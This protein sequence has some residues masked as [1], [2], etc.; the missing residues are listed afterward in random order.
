M[1]RS[2]MP[3]AVRG[4]GDGP[5]DGS[6]FR[7]ARLPRW[8]RAH[9]V[10]LLV[11]GCAPGH[12]WLDGSNP[13]PS[14]HDPADDTDWWDGTQAFPDDE[15]DVFGDTAVEIRIPPPIVLAHGFFGFD[16]FAGADFITYFYGVRE[17]LIASGERHVYTPAVDPFSDSRTR[18]DALL[19]HVLDILAETGAEKVNLVAH[20]Q[21]GLDARR[22]A[23]LRPDLVESVT[24]VATPHTGTPV[25]DVAVGAVA[26]SAGA[27]VDALVAAVAGPLWSAAGDG[28][29]LSASL[30][31]L[32]TAGAVAFN[33]D[34]PPG[35]G[36]V[37]YSIGGRSDRHAGG[38]DCEVSGRMPAFLRQWQ[39]DLDPIDPLLALTEG[40]ADGG[41]GA[42]RPNDGL[43]RVFDSRYGRFLGCIPAD[44]FDEIGHL[45][46]D[47]AGGVNRFDHKAFYRE[48]VAWLRAEGH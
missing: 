40:I 6:P 2:T 14:D 34:H 5:E 20:S 46:D 28:T 21:G 9:V 30:Q 36:V 38:E 23:S 15:E 32:S 13:S 48:L 7:T 12:G 44:H 18:G 22:V 24:T 16:T 37:Y 33:R 1:A 41:L 27:V 25:A 29:S 4:S 43:V 39:Y 35:A 17:D 10:A 8:A 45:L 42:N 19:E 47:G 11:A 31:Q 26:G 3:S